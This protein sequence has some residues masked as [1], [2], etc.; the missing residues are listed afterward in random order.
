MSLT[1]AA[2]GIGGALW[3]AVSSAGAGRALFAAL[4]IRMTTP[5]ERL[6]FEFGLGAGVLGWLAFFAGT[7][8]LLSTS[9]LLALTALGAAGLLVG[10]G[11]AE[12][13]PDNIPSRME[14]W[15]PLLLVLLAVAALFDVA[16]AL[17][18]PA[19][20]DS[21]AYHFALPK[22]FL[23]EGHIVFVPRAVDGAGPM[24]L[25][26]TYM[27][28]LG[29]G[30]ETGMTVW[31]GMLGWAAVLLVYALARRHLS[32][33]WALTVAVVFAITPAV[34]YGGGSGQLEV[35]LTLFAVT[36]ALLV[37]T[38]LRTGD[39]RYAAAAGIACGFFAASKYFGLVF[40]AVSGLTILLQRRW[41]RHGA[42]FGAAALIAGSQWYIWNYFQSGDPV[43]PLLYDWL[44]ARPGY[45]SAEAA[46]H[47]R[48]NYFPEEGPSAIGPW[49]LVSYPFRA[50]LHSL[51]IWD[52][53]RTGLGP[54]GLLLLPFAAAGVWRFRRRLAYHPLAVPALITA[55]F[56]V[57]WLLSGTSQRVRHLLPV[58]P[59]FLVCVTLAAL[60]FAEQRNVVRPL[61]AA[62]ALTIGIQLGG[63]SVFAANYIR[64]IASGEG[65]EA[66]LLRN[67]ARFG[68]VPWINA[69]LKSGD[70]ILITERQIS[71]YLDV[72]YYG[73]F[74]WAQNV[75]NL[76]KGQSSPAQFLSEVR[77][78]G[79]THILL[80]PSLADFAG[81][82]RHIWTD[83]LGRYV[84]ALAAAGC[85]SVIHTGRMHAPQSRT[86]PAL[87]VNTV[88]ADVVALAPR[89]PTL[90][91]RG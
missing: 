47:L 43:F 34:V 84:S 12:T 30:G 60:R 4:G 20:A 15:A 54:Y 23:T 70:R 48:Q 16:E 22:Q 3:L 56:Y 63:A 26:M 81:G 44:G 74:P 53:G 27:L 39:A 24:L 14:G 90:Q 17:A 76:R 28:A 55:A 77:R 5:T 32:R 49:L 11:R 9:W 91:E 45:W 40:L 6:A 72:P 41:L 29:I 42:A 73:G 50:T 52:A 89:C 66:F 61:A 62:C 80:A 59:V 69:H 10:R 46:A 85:A 13:A 19:D 36:A 75:V 79:I 7:G 71:Y 57:V 87:G 88:S 68:P 64:H 1:T 83:D 18:P 2:I 35:K 37:A 65:R 78:L 51:P 21:L 25:T 82:V 58:Y 38:A 8:G 31:A 33:E 86:V 67:V